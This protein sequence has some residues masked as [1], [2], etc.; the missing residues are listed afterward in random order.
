MSYLLQK[1]RRIVQAIAVVLIGGWLLA[2]AVPAQADNVISQ[3]YHTDVN[4]PAAAAVSL[5]Q[6]T[7]T[8]ATSSNQQNLYGV[9]VKPTDVSVNIDSETNQVEVVTTGLAAV[10]VSNLNGDIHI[11]DQLSPSP[12]AGVVMKASE[13]GRILGVAQ[14][15]FNSS[16]VGVT[17]KTLTAKDGSTKKV[18]VGTVPVTIGVGDYHS[19]D[20]T[21]PTVL[22]PFQSLFSNVSGHPVSST[23]TIASL[24]ILLLALI[25]AM[26]I[27]YSA[28]TGSVRS[29]GRNPL[30]K[31]AIFVGLLQV[32]V[33]VVVILL[34][35][36]SIIVVI[37][38]G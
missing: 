6:N 18:V 38:R 16:S 36:F 33:L 21:L 3:G 31:N 22:A 10:A 32:I 17:S 35:T 30:G 4:L 25:V 29:L 24:L 2:L 23:R 34:I 37:I 15:A 9:V 8:P 20:P 7:I 1:S 5:V 13:P 19:S 26:V 12:I 28:V 11:G 14:A 27:V